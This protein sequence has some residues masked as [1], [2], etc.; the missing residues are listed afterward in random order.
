MMINGRGRSVIAFT[1]VITAL[2]AG[3]IFIAS[4][5]AATQASPSGSVIASLVSDA[6]ETGQFPFFS[7]FFRSFFNPFLKLF[8]FDREDF[9]ENEELFERRPFLLERRDFSFLASFAEAQTSSNRAWAESD[10]LLG[11][12]IATDFSH[13]TKSLTLQPGEMG[14]SAPDDELRLFVND[15]TMVLMCDEDKSF[16][17]LKVG[18]MV[19]V[20][21][22]EM[23]GLSVADFIYKPC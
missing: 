11:K 21:Y 17:D 13:R 5:S 19:V 16:R 1:I 9:L 18:S 23:A 14:P 4:D 20:T 8:F 7:P 10:T 15:E 22:Y 6:R 3:M 2:L 12:I